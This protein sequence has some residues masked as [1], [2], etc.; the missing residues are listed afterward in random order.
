[1]ITLKPSPDWDGDLPLTWRNYT[2]RG[3][4]LECSPVIV[5]PNSHYLSIHKHIILGDGTVQPSVVCP[6][7]GWHEFVQLEGWMCL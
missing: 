3:K 7:C 4:V 6:G 1:M 5:D 2:Y